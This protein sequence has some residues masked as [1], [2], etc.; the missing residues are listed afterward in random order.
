M[1]GNADA[2]KLKSLLTPFSPG[3]AAARLRYAN[4]MAECEIELGDAGR[5]RLDDLLLTAPSH[6]LNPENV[7]IV[8]Q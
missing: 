6:W 8:Y 1:Q 3:P 7:E 2:H 4:A 5:V